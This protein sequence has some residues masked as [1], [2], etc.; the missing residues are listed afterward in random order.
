[1]SLLTLS[2]HVLAYDDQVSSSN[3][4][5]RV[6]DWSRAMRGLVTET[7][8]SEIVK[9]APG[10]EAVWFDGTRTTGFDGTT[11]LSLSLSP[12]A[13]DRYRIEWTGAGTLPAFRVDRSFDASSA[14]LTLTVNA[15]STVTVTGVGPTY[16]DVQVGDTVLIPGPTTG[17]PA[18]PFSTENEGYWTALASTP[19]SMVLARP[20]GVSFS[21]VSEVVAVASMNEILAFSS[22]RVQE[23]DKLEILAGFVTSARRSYRVLSAAPRWLDIQSTLP[24]ADETAVPGVGGLEVYSGAKAWYYAEADQ[25]VAVKLNGDTGEN[26]RIE[27]FEAGDP[28]KVGWAF[29]KGT[30]WRLAL[31]NRSQS[32]AKVL[33]IAAA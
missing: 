21:G 2:T 32:I 9:L 20:S 14:T 10:E 12:L 16:S 24:L 29:K 7:P 22:D 6:V 26:N 31:L 17:D 19:T 15:N 5:L 3:P 30:V 4:Q 33:V 18:S 28:D 27:P 8:R 1:M 25:E 23:G 13:A 11:E